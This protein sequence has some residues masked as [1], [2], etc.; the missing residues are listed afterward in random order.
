VWA[1]A[2]RAVTV[3]ALRMASE[4]P[5]SATANLIWY[6]TL[7]DVL[8][9]RSRQHVEVFQEFVP[10][11]GLANEEARRGLLAYLRGRY[12]GRPPD[13]VIASSSSVRD[14]ALRN[15]N[16]LFPDAPLVV[17][18]SWMSDS[19]RN[20]GTG[21]A[22]LEMSGTFGETLALAL[23]LHPTATRVYVLA[24]RSR[25]A[26][27]RLR[28]DLERVAGGV[29]L[30]FISEAPVPEMLDT[31][32]HLPTDSVV[33]YVNYVQAVRGH[34]LTELQIAELVSRES[35][36]PVY[37]FLEAEIGLGIVGG[38]VLTSA[39]E[40]TQLATL[41]ARVLNGEPPRSIA[42]EPVRLTRIFD[43]RQLRRWSIDESRLPAGSD[44]RFRQLTVWDRHRWLILG[45]LGTMALQAAMIVGL[46]I[47]RARRREAQR[48]LQQSEQRYALATSAGRVG[49]W[50][51]DLETKTISVDPALAAALGCRRDARQPLDEW[52][53]RVH[54]DDRATVAARMRDHVAGHLPFYE[55]EHRMVDR[56]GT[57]CWVLARGTVATQ[58][59]RVVGT[60]TDTTERKRAE[61]KLQEV[62]AELARIGRLNALGE[63]AASIAHEVRQPLTAIISSARAAMR[64]LGNGAT[65]EAEEALSYVL[66][67]S[68]RADA[69]IERNRELFRNRR[70]Q[71]ELL[72]CNAVV[73]EAMAMA[74][75]TLQAGLVSAV[76]ALADHLPAIEG[77]R[78]E[79]QQVLLNLIVNAIEAMESVD[80]ADRR[81]EISTALSPSGEVQVS[82]SDR[83]VGLAAVDLQR[84][85][86]LS[87]T[88][89]TGG[90]GVG[91]SISR[92]IIEAHG[93]RLWAER[94]TRGATFSFTVPAAP[95]AAAAGDAIA[96]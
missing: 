20:E 60:I 27:P 83:G 39:N 52:L 9:A 53:L 11:D 66:D 4:D 25:H 78:I 1:Q 85:F 65:A 49:V 86:T 37:G 73:G 58:S 44:V 70:V 74:R 68:K 56:A 55:L 88:T 29:P 72:D 19:I 71:K 28:A 6:S 7:R 46:V 45:A 12:R 2:P 42:I 17:G 63:F 92:S 82:V 23:H 67:A 10:V 47:Q 59:G 81:L 8:H 79:L 32:K 30:T 94:R 61:Q 16:A 96:V 13:L 76:T 93:G 90:T 43:W 54:A 64:F 91:L 84:L 95:T 57:V 33:F 21:V 40:A 22:A 5:G 34:T 51:L 3:L 36:V 14:F 62:Q 69:V 24:G 50:D 48:A 77:D 80:A 26:I 15:R 41:A 35:P 75:P 38:A 31:I 89:K 18:G 87:Y